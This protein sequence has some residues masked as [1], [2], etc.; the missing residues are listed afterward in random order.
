MKFKYQIK[1]K[2]NKDNILIEEIVEFKEID[3]S[4][5]ADEI[6]VMRTLNYKDDLIKKYIEITCEKLK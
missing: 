1:L 3:E 5:Y 2:G 6:K 4:N